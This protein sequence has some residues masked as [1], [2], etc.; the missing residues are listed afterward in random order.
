[1]STPPEQLKAPVAP[2]PANQKKKKGASYFLLDGDFFF[3][4]EAVFKTMRKGVCNLTLFKT[5]TH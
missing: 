4:F 3:S 2:A 1:M 5:C